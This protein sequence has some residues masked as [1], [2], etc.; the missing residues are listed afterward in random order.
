MSLI[1]LLVHTS[2]LASEAL[3]GTMTVGLLPTEFRRRRVCVAKKEIVTRH[4]LI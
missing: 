2:L 3:K 1:Q 4:Q